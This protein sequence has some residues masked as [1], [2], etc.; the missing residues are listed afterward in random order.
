VSAE[1]DEAHVAELGP[2][3]FRESSTE[4][5]K[6]TAVHERSTEALKR[7]C[8][9]ELGRRSAC[10]VGAGPGYAGCKLPRGHEGGHLA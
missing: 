2:R 4:A 8:L 1:E 10:N 6:H 7:A 3:W 9:E 5:L